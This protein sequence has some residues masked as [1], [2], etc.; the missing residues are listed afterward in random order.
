[1][2]PKSE[3]PSR[4][5]LS[6]FL[7]S[8]SLFSNPLSLSVYLDSESKRIQFRHPSRDENFESVKLR[9]WVFLGDSK[10]HRTQPED[11]KV[12]QEW[13]CVKCRGR[14]WVHEGL[15]T[16]GRDQE[17]VS[18]ESMDRRSMYVKENQ[19]GQNLSLY[20]ISN[21]WT[22]ISSSKYRF[23]VEWSQID[24]RIRFNESVRLRVKEVDLSLPLSLSRVG[25]HSR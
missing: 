4:P 24:G 10:F 7:F 12:V 11:S 15:R 16:E 18:E 9:D 25:F 3:Y 19:E 6:L 22:Q 1:M 5:E 8:S 23:E 14:I 20:C 13:Q 17:R 2:V 21:S